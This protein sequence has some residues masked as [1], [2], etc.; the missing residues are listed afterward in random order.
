[1]NSKLAA[2]HRAAFGSELPTSEGAREFAIQPYPAGD[3]VQTQPVTFCIKL[4]DGSAAAADCADGAAARW[5]GAARVASKIRATPIVGASRENC[6]RPI[7]FDT[8]CG[9]DACNAS[10][11]N[12]AADFRLLSW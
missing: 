8:L 10:R 12:V 6:S 2:V 5:A 1:L 4:R 11:A 7:L 3:D 9:I